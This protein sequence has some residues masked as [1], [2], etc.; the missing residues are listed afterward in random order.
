MALNSADKGTN[1]P[2]I[3]DILLSMLYE[4]VKQSTFIHMLCS[5]ETRPSV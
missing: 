1:F 3:A 4:P 2:N 5:S